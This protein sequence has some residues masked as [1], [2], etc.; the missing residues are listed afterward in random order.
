M[1][2]DNN[3]LCKFQKFGELLENVEGFA[4]DSVSPTDIW[5][6]TFKDNSLTYNDEFIKKVIFKLFI[7]NNEEESRGLEYETD[8][9]EHVIRPLI[10]NNICPNFVKY[11]GKG[12]GCNFNS[13]LKILS[14]GKYDRQLEINLKRN[15]SCIINRERDRPSIN[16]NIIKT[17]CRDVGI[18]YSTLN[19]NILLTE[20]VIGI[21]YTKFLVNIKDQEV[22]LHTLIIIRFII[23]AL[24]FTIDLFDLQNSRL[25]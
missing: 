14:K 10:D 17:K 16:N 22:V 5:L 1:D 8:I 11:M 12:I 13:L 21:K 23:P 7:D 2:T 9:Y 15:I 6:V 3:N 24:G 25:L 19:F 20:Q 18:N 4:S